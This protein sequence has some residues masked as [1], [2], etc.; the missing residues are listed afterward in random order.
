MRSHAA[1]AAA[2]AAF[3]TAMVLM[4]ALMPG[5]ASPVLRDGAISRLLNLPSEFTAAV[6]SSHEGVSFSRPQYCL[7]CVA[8]LSNLRP[9]TPRRISRSSFHSHRTTRQAWHVEASA[10]V[11]KLAPFHCMHNKTLLT[12]STLHGACVPAS[13]ARM[14]AWA[15]GRVFQLP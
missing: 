9:L 8:R 7:H 13:S 14:H 12:C 15:D 6:A 10:W 4:S 2:V 3:A 1:G 5:N 11:A